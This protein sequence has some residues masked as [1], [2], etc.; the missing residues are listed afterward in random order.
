[1]QVLAVG[2]ATLDIINSVP[3]YPSEDDELRATSHQ[4]CRGGNATNTLVVLSQL[5]HQCSWAGVL[6]DDTASRLILRDLQQQGVDTQWARIQPEGFTPTSYILSSL[7]TG[8]RT[9]VHYRDLPEYGI[10][11]FEQID[12][13]NYAWIHFEGREVAVYEPMLRH[14]RLAA[15]SATLS[16]E[17]EKPRT[18]IERLIPLADVVIIAKA[19][20]SSHGYQNAL[21]L[22]E[23]I[24]TSPGSAMLFATWGEDG[25][26]LQTVDGHTLYMPAYRPGR[27]VDT[28]GAGDVFNAGVI[29]GLQAGLEPTEVLGRAVRLAGEK[30]GRRGLDIA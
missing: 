3:V 30:C 23:A 11:A 8:S 20:A 15:P 6:G 4:E 29:D 26:W 28:L 19:Y 12:L 27:V 18:D 13:A 16:L 14:A 25:A 1:M 24:G 21:D 7:A 22:F 9:I 5:G 10:E 2:G 17:I